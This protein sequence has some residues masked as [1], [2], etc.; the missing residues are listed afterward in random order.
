MTKYPVFET[1]KAF[2]L[3]LAN[4]LRLLGW[5][6]I[7]TEQPI[8]KTQYRLDI[9]AT[10]NPLNENLIIECKVS[11]PD[12]LANAIAQ[13]LKYRG[14]MPHPD[15]YKWALSWPGDEPSDR[16]KQRMASHLISWLSPAK[17]KHSVRHP[18]IDA[19][20]ALSQIKE[21]IECHDRRA[22]D[23]QHSY[24]KIAMD[25]AAYKSSVRLIKSLNT[26]AKNAGGK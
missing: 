10:S 14:I 19:E 17:F 11:R 26:A 16:D 7:V 13:V 9:L 6:N 1:E 22:R 2:Q 12:S 20:Y 24:N 15:K 5:G 23:L 4:D 3:D 25:L 18:E 21:Q 8:S